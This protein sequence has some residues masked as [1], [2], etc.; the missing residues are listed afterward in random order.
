MSECTQ[1]TQPRNGNKW[2]IRSGPLH[3]WCQGQW[4]AFW[5]FCFFFLFDF[6]AA[7]FLPWI[8]CVVAFLSHRF[9]G[10]WRDEGELLCR[11]LSGRRHQR[12]VFRVIAKSL[13]FDNNVRDQSSAEIISWPVNNS[14]RASLVSSNNRLITSSC[15][16]WRRSLS[17]FVHPSITCKR[18][19]KEKV[20]KQFLK[21]P[22]CDRRRLRRW[23]CRDAVSS[24]SHRKWR[25]RVEYRYSCLRIGR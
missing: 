22:F 19:E 9:V 20:S 21:K 17:T 12:F 4:I 11:Q 18:N 7:F 1:Q 8:N 5:L 14:G 25:A 23:W 16:V 3:R 2:R 10:K 24:H 13:G 6:F 15:V